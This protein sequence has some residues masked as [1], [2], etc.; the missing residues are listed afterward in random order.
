MVSIGSTKGT[1]CDL[2]PLAIGVFFN[3]VSRLLK[4]SKA[5][6][7]LLIKVT[8]VAIP[9]SNMI[10]GMGFRMTSSSN[11]STCCSSSN[12]TTA[13]IS[14]GSMG[15]GKVQEIM[16]SLALLL[17]CSRSLVVVITSALRKLVDTIV[18]CIGENL[19]KIVTSTST[20]LLISQSYL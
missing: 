8:Y 4:T 16:A 11:A 5:W 15:K 2:G 12:V 7:I 1:S 20:N 18:A 3:T 10:N 14:I 9:I 17:T 19:L 13:S 6:V